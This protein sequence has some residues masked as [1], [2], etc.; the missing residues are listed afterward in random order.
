[1]RDSAALCGYDER[2]GGSSAN[3]RLH[4]ILE[5]RKSACEKLRYLQRQ[6]DQ[7][8]RGYGAQAT[9][10]QCERRVGAVMRFF[11]GTRAQC[12]VS[13]RIGF[14]SSETVAECFET[15]ELQHDF[16]DGFV[17]LWRGLAFCATVFME[18]IEEIKNKSKKKLSPKVSSESKGVRVEFSGKNSREK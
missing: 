7:V 11:E 17:G 8:F 9:C 2:N 4:Q 15:G 6:S 16:V 1:M 18:R 10:F 5:G 13:E 12:E 14:E 3:P